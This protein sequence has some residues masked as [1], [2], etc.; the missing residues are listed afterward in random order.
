MAFFYFTNFCFNNFYFFLL[1]SIQASEQIVGSRYFGQLC[2]VTSA[3]IPCSCLKRGSPCWKVD[4]N[5]WSVRSQRLHYTSAILLTRFEVIGSK[6]RFLRI[7]KQIVI[8]SDLIKKLCTLGCLEVLEWMIWCFYVF[9][10]LLFYVAD[11][12]PCSFPMPVLMEYMDRVAVLFAAS[13]FRSITPSMPW[14]M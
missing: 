6:E 10:S 11:Y 12:P 3:P 14:E 13:P 9:S 1:P 5:L 7:R 8:C 4:S 2:A